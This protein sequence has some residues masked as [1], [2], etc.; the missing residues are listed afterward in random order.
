MLKIYVKNAV[1]YR[2]LLPQMMK[3]MSYPSVE[4]EPSYKLLL[5]ITLNLIDEDCC[6]LSLSVTPNAEELNNSCN[7]CH[8]RP[9]LM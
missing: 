3:T 1:S 5:F 8:G 6:M 7:P 2:C 4:D 9:T